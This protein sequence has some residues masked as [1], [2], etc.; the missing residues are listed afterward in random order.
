MG[1][2]IMDLKQLEIFVAV[3]ER[4]AMV[5]LALHEL[6]HADRGSLG[7]SSLQQFEK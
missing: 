7:A 2:Y 6:F 1:E 5:I 4:A 3:A